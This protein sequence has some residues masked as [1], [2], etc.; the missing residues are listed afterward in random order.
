MRGEREKQREGK[1]NKDWKEGNERKRRERNNEY[2]IET[3]KIVVAQPLTT[4]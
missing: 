2:N 4:N 1:K 3:A